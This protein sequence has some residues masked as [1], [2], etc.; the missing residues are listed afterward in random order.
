M[1]TMIHTRPIGGG[2]DVSRADAEWRATRA[3]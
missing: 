3:A 2:Y 1:P